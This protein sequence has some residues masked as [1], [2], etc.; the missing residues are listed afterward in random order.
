[1][2]C[3]LL[4]ACGSL[5]NE[6]SPGLIQ[7]QGIQYVVNCY[8]S[9]QDTLLAATVSLTNPVLTSTTINSTTANESRSIVTLADGD[10][11]VVLPYDTK[12]AVYGTDPKLFPIRE[13][14]T[15]TLTVKT[16]DGQTLTSTATVPKAVPIQITTLDSIQNY[17]GTT[18]T[19]E[20]TA[21][22]IWRDSPGQADFYRVA[23]QFVFT[24]LALNTSNKPQTGQSNLSF[25]RN[26]NAGDFINDE[27][28]DGDA[29]TSVPGYLGIS[30]N[31][32]RNSPNP[33]AELE[34]LTLGSTYALARI[35]MSLLHTDENYYR[36][37][38]AV[39]RQRNLGGNP[40]AE[41]IL[42]P[43]NIV[44]GLGCFGA[45]NRAAATL[46]IK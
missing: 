15:Y 30:F 7:K 32:S 5:K 44:G 11:F 16:A 46:K 33:Q 34:K 17:N 25:R 22:I 8:I 27:L 29:L 26:R 21:Q 3:S 43:N 12:R 6:V 41:P 24:T 10:R 14:R 13:G 42:I 2:I 31:S 36:Y 20:Y 37:H 4:A 45:Y 39:L 19:K 9:P 1:M 38:E 40:F 23:G 35:D 18:L 28:A